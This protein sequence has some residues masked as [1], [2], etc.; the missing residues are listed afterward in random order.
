MEMPAIAGTTMRERENPR[1]LSLV[2][3]TDSIPVRTRQFPVRQPSP[4]L[5]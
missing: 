2:C 3:S 5:Q 1:G 4:D